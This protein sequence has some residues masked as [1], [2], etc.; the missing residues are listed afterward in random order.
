MVAARPTPTMRRKPPGP[1]HDAVSLAVV[2]EEDTSSLTPRYACG[3][4]SSSDSLRRAGPPNLLARHEQRERRSQDPDREKGMPPAAQDDQPCR[5]DDGRDDVDENVSSLRAGDIECVDGEPECGQEVLGR[6]QRRRE[7]RDVRLVS[8]KV[9]GLQ[10]IDRVPIRAH[11]RSECEAGCA[12]LAS[13]PRWSD[14]GDPK[15]D[16]EAIRRG[17]LCSE[18]EGS[19]ERCERDVPTRLAEEEDRGGEEE[20]RDDDVVLYP[21]RLKH[22][23]RE[24]QEEQR[25][26]R[27]FVGTQTHSAP[28]LRKH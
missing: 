11:D 25:A 26:E 9:S 2:G 4:P 17:E 7:A 10:R 19:C 8:Q 20:G 16:R 5:G 3:V 21:G 24:R 15:Q 22:D 28:R 14:Q 13:V 23:D 12:A 1:N 18:G 27:G 6:A